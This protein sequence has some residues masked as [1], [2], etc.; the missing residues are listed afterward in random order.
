M[1]RVGGGAVANLGED[2]NA[3]KVLMKE[4]EGQ[5]PFGNRMHIQKNNIKVDILKIWTS[6]EF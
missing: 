6:D 2:R 1:G 5:W 4:L 3:Y